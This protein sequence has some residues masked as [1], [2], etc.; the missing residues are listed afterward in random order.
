[1]FSAILEMFYFTPQIICRN[2]ITVDKAEDILS[3][4]PAPVVHPQTRFGVVFAH[5]IFRKNKITIRNDRPNIENIQDISP[6]YSTVS[7]TY[8]DGSKNPRLM[9]E[10][11]SRDE[12][13]KQTDLKITAAKVGFQNAMEKLHEELTLAKDI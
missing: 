5:F 8:T 3:F 6:E 4:R 2:T 9:L 1:M 13:L 7:D 11:A 12:K 10:G